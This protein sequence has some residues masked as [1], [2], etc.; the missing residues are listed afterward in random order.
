MVDLRRSSIALYLQLATLFRQNIASGAWGVGDQI[1]TVDALAAEFS[2]ARA[3][4][5]QA[6]GIL[7]KETLIE[8]FRAKG[9]FVS[10]QPPRHLW[11]EVSTDWSGL[12]RSR[13]GATIELLSNERGAHPVAAWSTGTLAPV[14]R[15][16]RRR[17][18]RDGAPFLV[19]DIY[20]DERLYR[21]VPKSALTNKMSLQF[22][23]E[24]PGLDVADARQILTIS[25]ANVRIAELL[26][27]PLNAPVAFVQRFAVDRSGGLVMLT[28]GTYRGDVVRIDFKLR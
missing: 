8:R 26:G 22:L 23:T 14:Y 15:H 7:E 3:T 17:H 20:L 11:C 12:L 9:T 16:L 25:E 18:S 6:L 19:S 5:R 24:I 10:R 4:I 28:E 1:P 13:E 2:V 27:V 21:R